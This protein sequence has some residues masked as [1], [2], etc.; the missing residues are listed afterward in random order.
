MVR[1]YVPP[2]PEGAPSEPAPDH[3]LEKYRQATI[4]GEKVKEKPR[5]AADS[6]AI[7][8]DLNWL[9]VN[10]YDPNNT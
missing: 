3:L 10:A 7:D 1:L 2:L 9:I 8:A 4:K 6:A 5:K